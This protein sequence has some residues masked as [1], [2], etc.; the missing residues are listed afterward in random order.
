M[1]GLAAFPMVLPTGA[2]LPV[3]VVVVV[4]ISS[5]LLVFTRFNLPTLG[6]GSVSILTLMITLC[7]NSSQ[8]F[9]TYVKFANH[10]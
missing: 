6:G 1:L 8:R 7:L 9:C 3:V 10:L 2:T 4:G 5:A